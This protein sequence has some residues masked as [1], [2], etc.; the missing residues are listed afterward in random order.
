MHAT[1]YYKPMMYY[2][3]TP[4][5]SSKFGI[6]RYNKLTTH[7]K[8]PTPLFRAGVW[9]IAHGLI[10][11]SKLLTTLAVGMC[12]SYSEESAKEHL[13]GA[14]QDRVPCALGISGTI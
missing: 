12:I 6:G 14:W 11:R 7:Y 1:M 9:E 13:M 10:I 5:F 8:R 3:H 2:K 4:L